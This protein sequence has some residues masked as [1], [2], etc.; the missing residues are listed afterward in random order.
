MTPVYQTSTYVQ[1]SPGVHVGRFDYARTGN[2]T[3]TALEEN[4]ASLEKGRFGLCFASGCA[5]M[6]TVLMSLK[7]GAHVVMCDDVY[8]GSFRLIHHVF[9]DLGLSYTLVDMSV[10][11]NVERACT[12]YTKLVWVETPTNPTLKVV[13]IRA[14]SD[15]ARKHNARTVVDNTFASPYLQ[16]PLELGA[17]MVCH[18]VTKYLGGHSDLIG[19]ALVLN[20]EVWHEKLQYL[21]NAVGA[22]PAPWDCF[23][24]LRSTKTLQVRMERHCANAKKIAEY[25]HTHRA[26]ERVYYPGLPSHPTHAIAKKQ[27]RDFGGM[28]SIV[29]KGGLPAAKRMLESVKLFS[30]AE[31]LGGVESL[32]EHPGIMTHAV[33]PKE[34]HEKLGV[35][36]GLV[37]LSV[38]IEAVEDL[39]SDIE[40]ALAA[41]EKA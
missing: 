32:I 41:A 28:I 38:G 39:L 11:E 31:S 2:P 3:R 12:P 27:M 19:G 35:V 6:S 14:I 30:L 24:T 15:I 16:N 5:A 20:D 26:V 29:L 36:D 9:A 33:I 25:L 17:D 18:S 34:Q 7:S 8:G 4:L 37:R 40:Q 1:P 21:Q 23:L 22:V 10:L 13:D